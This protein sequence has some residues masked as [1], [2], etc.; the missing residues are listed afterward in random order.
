MNTNNVARRFVQSHP[1]HLFHNFAIFELNDE[2]FILSITLRSCI[3]SFF[4]FL[5]KI[6]KVVMRTNK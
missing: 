5:V 1:R 3:F 4:G 2:V 6:G